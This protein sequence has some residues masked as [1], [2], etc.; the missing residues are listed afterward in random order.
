M[1]LLSGGRFSTSGVPEETIKQLRVARP[2]LAIW[3]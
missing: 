1:P 2:A 3:Q